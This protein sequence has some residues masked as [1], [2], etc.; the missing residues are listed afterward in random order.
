MI[1]LSSQPD[2]P[3]RWRPAALGAGLAGGFPRSLQFAL[4]GR[5]LVGN[6]SAPHHERK[7]V[8]FKSSAQTFVNAALI[9]LGAIRPAMGSGLISISFLSG[10]SD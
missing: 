9:T 10:V 2:A 1:M 8:P 7:A 3:F 5:F 6:L 4:I